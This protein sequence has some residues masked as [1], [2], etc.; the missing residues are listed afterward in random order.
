MPEIL[1]RHKDATSWTAPERR[2]FNFEADLRD[3]LADDPTRVPGVGPGALAV[4]ELQTAAGRV[5]LCILDVNG[6]V[7]V[8]ECKL[9]SNSDHRRTI[10]GQVLDYASALCLGGVQEFASAWAKRSGTDPLAGLDDGAQRNL[11]E[12][13]ATRRVNLCLA[14]DAITD[15][16][17]RLV[18]YLNQV[19][20]A[21]VSVTALEFAYA[22]HGDLEIAVPTV[23]G[24]EIVEAKATRRTWTVGQV[25][26]HFRTHEGDAVADFAEA[27]VAECAQLGGT[28]TGTKATD[29]SLVVSFETT[30]G[31]VY[32]FALYCVPPGK[33]GT[34]QF[35]FHWTTKA[36][37]VAR[38]AFTEQVV[39]LVGTHFDS[40]DVTALLARRP[41]VPVSAVAGV[42]GLAL[43]L[44]RAQ[45]LLRAE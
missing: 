37:E 21:D 3:L 5:D 14:V 15:E 27:L 20:L 8:V 41:N 34:V 10:I 16:V 2:S 19:T 29:P 18:E 24:T 13:F 7:T 39:R 22:S 26:E 1:V 44:A 38:I 32:P 31:T 35:C 25:M 28:A 17:R 23:F 9:G 40:D 36:P 33:L 4:T 12:S 11:E 43:E 30:R 42:D 6:A 45:L